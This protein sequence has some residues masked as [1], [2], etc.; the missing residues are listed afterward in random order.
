MIV[1]EAPG[2]EE[3]RAGIPFIGQSGRFLDE[4]LHAVGLLRGSCFV[5]NVCR[6]KPPANPKNR[7]PNDINLWFSSN[8]N[9]PKG[10]EWVR[11]GDHWVHPHIRD[12]YTLLQQEL[13]L[14][15]PKLII[16]LGNVSLW[17]LTGHTGISKWHG[18]RLSPPGV[19]G[20]V[21]PCIHPAAVLRQM[22]LQP[23]FRMAIQR[24]KDIYEGK[25]VPR[26]YSFTIEPTFGQVSSAL[27]RIL[28]LADAASS[29]LV[30]SGDIETR[31][32][33]I[34]CLG[35]ALNET[36]AV[37]IPFLTANPVRPFYWDLEQET[38]IVSLVQ[39][40]FKHPKILHVGQNYLY[41]CQYYG[42]HWIAKPVRVFDTMIG[43]HS[44]FSSMRKGLDFL[45]FMY[46]QDH[47]YWKDES[48]DWDPKVGEKQLWT[49]N[50][51]DACI[52]HEVFGGIHSMRKDIGLGQHFDFQQSL[53]FPVLRMMERGVKWDLGQRKAFKQQLTAAGKERRTLIEMMTGENLYGRTGVS[54]K[55]VMKFFYDTL[56]MP[57]IRSLK[58]GN[59]TADSDALEVIATREPLLRP[60]AAALNE[61]RTITTF[62]STFIDAEVDTDG[63]M[64]SAF[65]IAG[66]ITYRFSSN[67]NAFHSGLNFQNIPTDKSGKK[68]VRGTK[69]ELPNVR[70]LALPDPG[71]TFFDMDLDR[72]DLQVVV[73]EAE[74]GELKLVLRQGID[75]HCFNACQIFDIKGIPPD[76]LREDHPNYLDHR[77]RIG[78][79]YRNRAKQGVH[80]VDYGI[81]ARK[82]AITL[83]ITIYEAERFIARWLGAHPGIKKWH[84]RTEEQASKLGYI[85]NLFGARLYQFGRFDLPEA[86]GWLPQSTVAGVINRALIAI[87]AA[88]QS[89]QTNIQL[90]IQVH[91]SLAGQFPTAEREQSLVTLR[92]LSQIVVPY[93]D[94]LIIPVGIKT[95]EVSW[96]ACA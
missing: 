91:D 17:A 15:K 90:L 77:A 58:T 48:K 83:G 78:S 55:K 4:N 3:E 34:T 41:D 9:P 5:T 85:E 12:G 84:K 19:P 26:V 31:A 27:Y 60:L 46:A 35:F 21:V 2:Q 14:V 24:A 82:L 29:D 75:L 93:E 59:P 95:S 11:L 7:N 64:R 43:H 86:L 89:K 76:E 52:T 96:G 8:V 79:V 20:T 61:A 87:D 10:G 36:E 6:H 47:V 68:K 39:R 92:N 72:A 73:W 37:C 45:S 88:E 32:G 33:M 50:C 74:D 69:I 57:G 38:A 49:Y 51:K 71:F 44:L 54:S 13:D 18:S 30:L 66:P 67:E 53:F 40:I 65:N 70:S 22:E 16:A 25:Q 63:R 56:Q 81:G 1:G 42:R 23:A 28:A 94:P 80:A 62:E